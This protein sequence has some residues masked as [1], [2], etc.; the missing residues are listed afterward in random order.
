[1]ITGLSA[2]RWA[3]FTSEEFAALDAAV[4][5]GSRLVLALHAAHY[6]DPAKVAAERAQSGDDEDDL[7]EKKTPKKEIDNPVTGRRN[8]GGDEGAPPHERPAYVDLEKL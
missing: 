7:V 5:N 8:R 3:Q 4:H 1:M 2:K 6:V